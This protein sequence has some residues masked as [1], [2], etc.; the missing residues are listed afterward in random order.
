MLL[1]MEQSGTASAQS[2]SLPEKVPRFIS[3]NLGFG[4]KVS[5]LN[6]AIASGLLF[7]ISLFV[8]MIGNRRG[9]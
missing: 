5:F 1:S 6:S 2:P 7:V 3:S 9:I 8:L 4:G